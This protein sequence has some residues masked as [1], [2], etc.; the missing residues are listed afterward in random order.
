MYDYD[1]EDD[2]IFKTAKEKLYDSSDNQ[3]ADNNVNNNYQIEK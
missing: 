3:N 1:E 2:A